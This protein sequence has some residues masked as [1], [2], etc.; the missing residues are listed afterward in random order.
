M[1]K[2]TFSIKFKKIDFL[3]PRLLYRDDTSLASH[4]W[5]IVLL[6]GLSIVCYLDAEDEGVLHKTGSRH[7]RWLIF[8]LKKKF[9]EDDSNKKLIML[10]LPTRK[11]KI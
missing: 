8:G 7:C 4:V 6:S 3:L 11:N 10:Y 1:P 5:R 2:A 9:F